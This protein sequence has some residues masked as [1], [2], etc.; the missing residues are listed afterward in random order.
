M[1][2]SSQNRGSA[3]LHE[4]P[5]LVPEPATIHGWIGAG[6]G[7][8]EE[9]QR[10]LHD[11]LQTL[12]LHDMLQTLLHDCMLLF[13]MVLWILSPLFKKKSGVN[14]SE[15]NGECR[16]CKRNFSGGS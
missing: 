8:V 3:G 16:E 2:F 6:N 13:V 12:L 9:I 5:V 10:V 14:F 11:M 1:L 7:R 4:V 15:C